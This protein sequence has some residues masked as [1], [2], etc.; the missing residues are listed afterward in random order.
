MRRITFLMSSV[1]AAL[2]VCP[3]GR[4]RGICKQAGV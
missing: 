2:A 3:V 1:V 4:Q